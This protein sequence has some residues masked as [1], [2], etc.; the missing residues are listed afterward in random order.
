MPEKSGDEDGGGDDE[1]KPMILNL[2]INPHHVIIFNADDD[3]L[4]KRVANLKEDDVKGTHYNEKDI[5]RR[6]T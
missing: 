6:L 4:I 2:R 5:S 3:F 1:N